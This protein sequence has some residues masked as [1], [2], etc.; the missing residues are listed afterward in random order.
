[1]RKAVAV[2]IVLLASLT[3]ANG[4]EL[5][6]PHIVAKGKFVNQNT[7]FTKTIF[8]PKRTG[9]YRISMYMTMTTNDPHSG[10]NWNVFLDWIDD[11]GPQLTEF[12][13]EPTG[14]QQGVALCI[15]SN[16]IGCSWPLEVTATTP[17]TLS[18][19]QSGP[20]DNSA[21][22]LYYVIEALAS[23]P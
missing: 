16:N 5:T 9:L 17:I 7:T 20:P 10:S 13:F 22:S 14:A 6:S 23:V 18:V 21:Y 15:P 8:T 2:L 12:A 3:F 4:Q 19:S 1:M 11:S